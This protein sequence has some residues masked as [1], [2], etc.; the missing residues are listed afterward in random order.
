MMLDLWVEVLGLA[1]A[2]FVTGLVAAWLLW[3]LGR[4]L[5]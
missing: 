4:A 1:I 5:A 2:A 3:K